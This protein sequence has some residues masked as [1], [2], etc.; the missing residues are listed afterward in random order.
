MSRTKINWTRETWN[1]ITGCTKVSAGCQNC[2]MFKQATRNKAMGHDKYV[3]EASLTLHPQCL[4]EPR[5]WRKPRTVFVCSMADLFH[6]DVPFEFIRQVFK[7]MAECGQHTFQVLTKRPE[8]MAEFAQTIE[9]PS[10]VWAGT[11]IEANAY[12]RRADA[13][14]QVPAQVRFISA[15]PL[16]APLPDL[17]LEGIHWVIVGGESGKGWRPLDPDWARD[18]RD[19][20]VRGNVAFFFKQYAAF[21]PKK[22]G[23]ELDG[24]VWD[25]MPRGTGEAA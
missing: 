6:E 13:L 5:R 22:L 7:V 15:E 21:Q 2:Y 3:N 19:Q 10:N 14:R 1:P 20:C 24:I 16:L 25:E 9:W 8:R 12:V 4:D 17:E 23:R 18:L 11:S